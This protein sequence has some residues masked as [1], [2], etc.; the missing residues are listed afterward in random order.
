MHYVSERGKTNQA[1]VIET[2]IQKMLFMERDVLVV[3][4]ETLLLS[5]HKISPE[6]EAEELLKVR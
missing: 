3:I 4:T 1:L 5:L 6:G 2:S